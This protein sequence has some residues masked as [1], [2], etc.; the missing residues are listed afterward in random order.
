VPYSIARGKGCSPGKPWAVVK[1]TDGSVVACHETKDGALSQIRALYAAEPALAKARQQ[2]AKHPGHGDQKVHGGGRAPALEGYVR[3]S[4][5]TNSA[6]R[7][8]EETP[9]SRDMDGLMKESVL[10]ERLQVYRVV[11]FPPGDKTGAQLR[12]LKKGDTFTDKA[13]LST[14]EDIDTA[15]DFAPMGYKNKVTM[16]IRANPGTHAV[17]VPVDVAEK[18]GMGDQFEVILDRGATL[19]VV[20]R[21]EME[22]GSL[23][24]EMELESTNQS[25]GDVA[26]HLPGQHQ[27]QTHATGG[28]AGAS[29]KPAR[30]KR[31]KEQIAGDDQ[32]AHDL[33]ESGKSWD[34]VAQEM[35]FANGGV[36][37]RAGLRHAERAKQGGDSATKKP[38]DE[39]ATKKPDEASTKTPD[40]GATPPVVDVVTP[41]RPMTGTDPSQHLTPTDDFAE[42]VATGRPLRRLTDE[43]A[44]QRM[45]DAEQM[46]V[47]YRRQSKV[48]AAKHQ[49]E[50]DRRREADK[51][52]TEEWQAAYA[53]KAK[54]MPRREG[55]NEY[56]HVRRVDDAL[57]ADGIQSRRYG[58]VKSD[59]EHLSN[60]L[61]E[62]ILSDAD[63]RELRLH[64]ENG[65][66]IWDRSRREIEID[67]A[68]AML[69]ATYERRPVMETDWKTGEKRQMR[70]SAYVDGVWTADVNPVFE[71]GYNVPDGNG[72]TR[73]VRHNDIFRAENREYP[74]VAETAD[75][76]V[77]RTGQKLTRQEWL[78]DDTDGKFREGIDIQLRRQQAIVDSPHTRIVIHA[79]VSATAGITKSGFKSQLE[80][81]RSKGYKNRES[82][83]GFEAATLGVVHSDDDKSKG[84]IYGALHVG[85]VRDPAAIGAEQYGEVGF[86]L[87]RG[88]HERSTFTEGDSLSMC[89]ESSPLT[90]RQTQVN[91]HVGHGGVDAVNR[92][93]SAWGVSDE[94]FAGR[95]SPQPRKAHAYY[96]AQVLGGVSMDDIDYV[97]IPRGTQLPATAVKRLRERG[98]PIVE[99]DVA[100]VTPKIVRMVDNY[101]DKGEIYQTPEYEKGG[102]FTNLPEPASKTGVVAN[103]WKHLGGK[104]DQASHGGKRHGGY[105]LNDPDNPKPDASVP[106]DS[107]LAAKAMRDHIASIEPGMTRDMIDLAGA[108]GGEMVGLD[109]RLKSEKSLARKVEAEKADFGGDATKAAQ[110]MSDVARYTI[111]FDE[112]DYVKG[113]EAVVADLEAK[114]YKTR[115]KNYWTGNDPYQGIN[116]AVTH[117]D[118]TVFELQLHTPR[119]ATVKEKVHLI[120]D[121]Y[122][123]AKSPRER[124][125][126]YDSMVRISNAIPVPSGNI[127]GLGD[128]KVQPFTLKMRSLVKQMSEMLESA[129]RTP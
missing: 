27:Q 118:G 44:S 116:I 104:H 113:S 67:T 73:F 49:S 46:I 81:G 10:E 124:F 112:G 84:V 43:G 54:T 32:R 61:N 8:G 5:K 86:V 30:P 42:A 45:K 126:L 31:S 62:G 33:H 121:R 16:T 123:V 37:R 48:I 109:F 55:E 36:A 11:E 19:R 53:A 105:K 115:V 15:Q 12:G 34:E 9:A 58:T 99:Y 57:K 14:S 101:P 78:D 13:F 6:L 60:M 100:S 125:R 97:T 64:M 39:T 51:K 117:P 83:E 114:G 79:P 25:S 38:D 41:P 107:R 75:W 90:G 111:A 94:A 77:K 68:E 120:Y 29:T 66:G 69:G 119:S 20:R 59:H 96:E 22:D 47:D 127:L 71:D 129:W 21:T 103:I 3:D 7:R 26:K 65:K 128:L 1:D 88:V 98:I 35:G 50:I 18:V 110:A 74:V 80:T 87:K 40:D 2:V 89:Y 102:L 4:V 70:E 76:R 82:R 93:L 85:G 72:G 28:G 106:E 52:K 17:K 23:A 92:D 91:G 63:A 56:D 24:L 95:I 108:H 122:R